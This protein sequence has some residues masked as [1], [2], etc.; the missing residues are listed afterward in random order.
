MWLTSPANIQRSHDPHPV[1]DGRIRKVQAQGGAF[2]ELIRDCRRDNDLAG[3]LMKNIE[4]SKLVQVLERRGVADDFRQDD[5][6]A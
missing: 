4:F 5:S 6:L 1:N 3:K 2:S